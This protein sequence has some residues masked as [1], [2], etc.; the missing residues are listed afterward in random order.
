MEFTIP[1][2]CIWRYDPELMKIPSNA[3]LLLATLGVVGCSNEQPAASAAP[4]SVT[5]RVR[6]TDT[7]DVSY[8]NSSNGMDS[9]VVFA[10]DMPWEKT[11]TL[12]PG[13]IA[14]VTAQLK[15]GYGTVRAEVLVGGKVVD[16]SES[17]GAYQLAK[18]SAV[19]SAQ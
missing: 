11:V 13:K 16:S 1:F 18:A 14:Y 7:V 15:H 2:S 12:P 6:A 19:I 5:Y 17:T 4:V 9:E 8:P 10:S 3:A